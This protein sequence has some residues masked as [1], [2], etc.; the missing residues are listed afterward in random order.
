MYDPNQ[1]RDAEGKWTD[2]ASEITFKNPKGSG[3]LIKA[4]DGKWDIRMG[5][6][7]TGGPL[8]YDD[9]QRKSIVQRGMREGWEITAK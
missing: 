3:T 9:A 8:H 2:G 5:D 4:P 6:G 7:R 1:P